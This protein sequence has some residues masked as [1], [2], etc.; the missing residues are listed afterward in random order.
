MV[1]PDGN[2]IKLVDQLLAKKSGLLVLLSSG[3]TD[4]ESHL[5]LIQ[6]RKIHFLQKPYTVQLLLKTIKEIIIK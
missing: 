5:P 3:Y 1:L 6:E 4:E 2:G